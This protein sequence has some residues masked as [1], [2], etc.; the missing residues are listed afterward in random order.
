MLCPQEKCRWY[1][2]SKPSGKKCWYGQPQ[3]WKGEV[4][5]MIALLKMRFKKE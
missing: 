3:C 5:I 2:E 1:S 4:D